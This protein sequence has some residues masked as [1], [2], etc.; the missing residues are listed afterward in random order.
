MM[1]ILLETFRE[2]PKKLYVG[3]M[4]RAIYNFSTMGMTLPMIQ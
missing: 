3:G 4:F 1:K 2:N